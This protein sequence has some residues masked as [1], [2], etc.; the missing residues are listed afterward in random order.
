MATGAIVAGTLLAGTVLSTVGQIRAARA[1]RQQAEAQA[2]LKR[3]QGE[4]ILKRA[5]LNVREVAR[6]GQVLKG[7]QIGGFAKG[8]VELRGSAMTVLEDTAIRIAQKQRNIRYQ[9]E[10]EASRLNREAGIESA[11]GVQLEKAGMYQA[12]GTLLGG[13][14]S[15]AAAGDRFGLFDGGSGG[16]GGKNA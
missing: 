15:A 2:A 8:G 1:R 4:E 6:Q 7:R 14:G 10:W 5:E 13:L 16:G 9:A 12:G 11:L 3:E